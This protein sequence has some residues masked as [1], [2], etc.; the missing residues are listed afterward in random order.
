MDTV[1]SLRAPHE[2]P[3]WWA[4]GVH[5]GRPGADQPGGFPSGDYEQDM[6]IQLEY[7]AEQALAPEDVVM[8]AVL[9]GAK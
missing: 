4:H 1:H 6:R 3:N 7:H 5:Y 8:L 9:R 2:E